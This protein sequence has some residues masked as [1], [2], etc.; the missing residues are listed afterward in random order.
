VR[1]IVER[2]HER[3]NGS[4]YPARMVGDAIGL[5]G[6]MAGIVDTFL[7]LSGARSYAP[8]LPMDDCLRVLLKARG[9][10]FHAPLVESRHT[11]GWS[12]WARWR[13]SWRKRRG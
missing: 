2:H 12:A 3:E 5:Y 8:A 4:G 11:P 1:Q 7:A 6:R 9:T 10:L 13:P